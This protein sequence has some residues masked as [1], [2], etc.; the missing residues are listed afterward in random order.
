M[1]AAEKLKFYYET[2]NLLRVRELGGYPCKFRVIEG[3]L[4]IADVM[5]DE[6]ELSCWSPP[7]CERWLADFEH[8]LSTKK[9]DDDAE[10][11]WETMPGED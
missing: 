3:W 4:V 6:P 7:T 11:F 8:L 5:G 2:Y 10:A 9:Y 1:T